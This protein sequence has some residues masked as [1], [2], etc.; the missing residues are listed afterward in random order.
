MYS[1]AVEQLKL[2]E[3]IWWFDVDRYPNKLVMNKIEQM[4]CSQHISEMF[5][6][7]TEVI[8][9][10]FILQILAL[11]TYLKHLA[12]N[13]GLSEDSNLPAQAD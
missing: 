1:G 8:H 5:K 12:R 10:D 4:G 13:L 7:F 11:S 3:E 9:I 6:K 2:E